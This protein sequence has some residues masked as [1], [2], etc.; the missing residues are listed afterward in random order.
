MDRHLERCLDQGRFFQW[1]QVGGAVLLQLPT[2]C[3]IPGVIPK[4]VWL[5]TF[6]CVVG[7]FFF[8]NYFG[9]MR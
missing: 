8:A 2:A 4:T 9:D 1:I 7:R 3:Q 6:H 5:P